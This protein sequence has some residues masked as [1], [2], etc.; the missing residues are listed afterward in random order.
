MTNERIPAQKDGLTWPEWRLYANFLHRELG[1]LWHGKKSIFTL[2]KGD[3]ENEEFWELFALILAMTFQ[4]FGLAHGLTSDEIAKRA[5]SA[6]E[7]YD[8]LRSLGF[9]FGSPI[10]ECVWLVRQTLGDKLASE[11]LFDLQVT[12]IIILAGVACGYAAEGKMPPYPKSKNLRP[13]DFYEIL[14]VAPELEEQF[15]GKNSLPKS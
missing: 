14:P 12:E 1:R 8:R 6:N 11:F 13:I 7:M 15:Y 5:K 2:A 9:N 3:K 4:R 10:L